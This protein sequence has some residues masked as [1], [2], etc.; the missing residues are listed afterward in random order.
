MSYDANA[1]KAKLKLAAILFAGALSVAFLP[2]KA[3]KEVTQELIALFGLMMA[4]VLPTMV[5]T[6]SMLRAGNLSVKKLQD[7]RDAL[8]SQLSIWIG[9]F[10]ISLFASLFVIIGKMMDWSLVIPLEWIGLK[11]ISFDLICILNALIV[12]SLTLI[13]LRAVEVGKGVISLLRLSA[14]LAI[15]PSYS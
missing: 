8:H 11:S 3:F 2:P 15:S 4:G 1:L 7:Y 5:L 13:V 9:F 14:E 10:L 12:M 6:A